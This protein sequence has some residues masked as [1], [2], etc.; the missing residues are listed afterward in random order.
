MA[1][2]GQNSPNTVIAA[3]PFASV[4]WRDGNSVVSYR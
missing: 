2:F 1:R 4:G 3:L